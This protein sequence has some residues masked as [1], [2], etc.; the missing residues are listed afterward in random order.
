LAEIRDRK[1]LVLMKVCGSLY[2]YISNSMVLILHFIKGKKKKKITR[3]KITISIIFAK[4]KENIFCSESFLIYLPSFSGYII[5]ES[6][7]KFE[8]KFV[9]L[10]LDFKVRS[11]IK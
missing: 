3:N 10:F 8:V 4:L 5:V 9:S 6:K 7:K 11:Y 2:I 1:H